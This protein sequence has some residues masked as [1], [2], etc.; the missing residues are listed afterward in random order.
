MEEFVPYPRPN[1]DLNE[2][3]V[4]EVANGTFFTAIQNSVASNRQPLN[5]YINLDD[6]VLDRLAKGEQSIY[7]IDNDNETLDI[8][9]IK[10]WA[11]S[12]YYVEVDDGNYDVI[13]NP[14]K[15]YNDTLWTGRLDYALDSFYEYTDG[16]LYNSSSDSSY[17][18]F[19]RPKNKENDDDFIWRYG[20]YNLYSKTISYTSATTPHS[21][22]LHSCK[23]FSFRLIGGNKIE[24][25]NSINPLSINTIQVDSL[26]TAYAYE[27]YIFTETAGEMKVIDKFG[28]TKFVMDNS[29]PPKFYFKSKYYFLDNSTGGTLVLDTKRWTTKVYKDSRFHEFGVLGL[30][31]FY[32]DGAYRG[33]RYNYNLKKYSTWIDDIAKRER[34]FAFDQYGDFQHTQDNEIIHTFNFRRFTRQGIKFTLYCKTYRLFESNSGNVLG[35]F[36]K[37]CLSGSTLSTEL[38]ELTG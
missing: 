11:I 22:T 13:Y 19:Y 26:S 34:Y 30:Y 35:Y 18:I 5:R 16:G 15:H 12:P 29:S 2:L 4:K 33:S 27:D 28:M 38:F 17:I 3:W 14:R 36:G 9:K 1:T 6:N 8:P 25:I 21:A 31:D 24:I 37:I 10:E 23:G 20:L 32:K 7:D